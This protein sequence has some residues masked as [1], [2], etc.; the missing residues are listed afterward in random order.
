VSLTDTFDED[1]YL[2]ERYSGS[3]QQRSRK[4]S[5]YY[6]LKPFV[7]RAAIMAMRRLYARRQASQVFPR[8]PIE[9]ILVERSRAALRHK[10]EQ[11]GGAPVPFLNP[12]PDG[13]R[14]AVTLTH[15]VE[16]PEGIEKIPMV[17][18]V[19]RRYGFASAWYFV[20]EDYEI[21]SGVFASL[22]QDGCE[23]GLH[24]ITHDAKL[25]SSRQAFE[26]ELPKIHHYLAAWEAAGFRSPATH[27]NADWMPE[28]GCE[29]DTTFTDSAPFE[30]QPGGCCSI[31]PYF[32][33]DLVELPMT[34]VMDHTLWEILRDT[35]SSQWIRKAEWVIDNRGLVNLLVHPDYVTNSARLACYEDFLRYLDSRDDL[36]RALPRQV[37]GWWKA[38]AA[39]EE[40]DETGALVEIDGMRLAATVGQARI[41]DGALTLEPAQGSTRTA[42]NR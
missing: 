24:G 31:L 14:A 40:Q 13:A 1:Y 42:G 41:V 37:A 15:D 33:D 17:R 6:A 30:P 8:W 19:E 18:E 28:L 23:I 5:A 38:R 29:Y 7:P 35:S 26:S 16:G 34:L 25:F 9:P 39:L 10:V 22:R 2:R 27:R 20:A 3:R 21:P 12:W 11:A 32:L 36:W 4:V